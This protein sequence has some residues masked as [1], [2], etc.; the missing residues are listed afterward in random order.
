MSEETAGTEPM[1]AIQQVEGGF[2]ILLVKPL[3]EQ[4]EEV[5]KT[6]LGMP[7]VATAVVD[8]D[9]IVRIVVRLMVGANYGITKRWLEVLFVD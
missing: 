7:G 4:L 9:S 3:G 5:L 8:P 1:A 2:D 6:I